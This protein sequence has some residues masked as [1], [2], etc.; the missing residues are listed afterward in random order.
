MFSLTSVAL[1]LALPTYHT[2]VHHG[3]KN[4]ADVTW[5]DN[6]ATC[7]LYEILLTDCLS[8]DEF[9]SELTDCLAVDELAS[10]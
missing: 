1:P 8:V 9:A 4:A 7:H 10:E 2:L 5:K 3:K 6:I